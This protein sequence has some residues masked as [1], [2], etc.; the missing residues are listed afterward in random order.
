MLS[1]P[2][3][4]TGHGH[5]RLR[6]SRRSACVRES[7]A[8]QHVPGGQLRRWTGSAPR[9]PPDQLAAGGYGCVLSG[10]VWGKP[11]SIGSGH[12]EQNNHAAGIFICRY[13]S[14]RE[15]TSPTFTRTTR[16]PVRR[17]RAPAPK[18]LRNAPILESVAP[19]KC[20]RLAQITTL[21]MFGLYCLQTSSLV[22]S[23]GNQKT[24]RKA[25]EQNSGAKSCCTGRRGSA[26]TEL[27]LFWGTHREHQYTQ[28]CLRRHT[29]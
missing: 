26:V 3:P 14:S 19:F 8:E 9:T 4:L 2:A 25:P 13:S 24:G 6:S 10:E 1:K 17:R 18:C 5:R 20:V 15:R 28:S 16:L 23:P 27:F 29:Q 7:R 11:D 21:C 22:F 12:P